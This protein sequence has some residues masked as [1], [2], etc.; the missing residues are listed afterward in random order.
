M[1]TRL[2]SCTATDVIRVWERARFK[3]AVGS[4]RYFTHAERRGLVCVPFHRGDLKRGTLHGIISDAGLSA[5]STAGL[6][7]AHLA[8]R[9]P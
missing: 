8:W 3:R 5:V 4:H 2:P 1:S 7:R 9:R 6:P